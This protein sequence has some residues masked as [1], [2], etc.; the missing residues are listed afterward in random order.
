MPP[1]FEMITPCNAINKARK[2]LKIGG[3]FIFY[4]VIVLIKL[5]PT[6]I[7]RQKTYD[8]KLHK[9]CSRLTES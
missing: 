7:F 1:R 8:F 3:Y 2:F 4:L 6:E 5:Y 9:K